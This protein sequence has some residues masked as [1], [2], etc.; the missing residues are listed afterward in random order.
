MTLPRQCSPH[1]QHAAPRTQ[2]RTG[3][4]PAITTLQ[5]NLVLELP[6]LTASPTGAV[7]AVAHTFWGAKPRDS[8]W[9]SDPQTQ[10]QP[11]TFGVGSSSAGPPGRRQSSIERL[12][13]PAAEQSPA[14]SLQ[15]AGRA[16]SAA[17]RANFSS[18]CSQTCTEPHHHL[19]L[20]AALLAAVG[21]P[22]PWR[23]PCLARCGR[24]RF[25]P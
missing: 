15:E 3:S 16:P 19:P 4:V 13:N 2:E 22:L 10:L 11:P 24:K 25:L 1:G 9:D 12:R 17:Q 18:T 20:R 23:G 14:E 6:H 7:R 21:E 8:G 5:M